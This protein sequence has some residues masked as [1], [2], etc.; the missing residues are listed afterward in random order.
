MAT[1]IKNATLKVTVKEEITLNGSRQDSENTLRISDINE[2]SKR[3]VTVP[4]SE[5]T[6]VSMSTAGSAWIY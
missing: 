4:T 5:V 1:T 3:I 2:I 6:L